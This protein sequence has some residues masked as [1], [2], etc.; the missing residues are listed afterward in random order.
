M[1]AKIT[2]RMI[3]SLIT[4]DRDRFI[5]DTEIA[6]FGIKHTRVG[7]VIYIVQSRLSGK[8]RRYTI[9]RHGA[10]WTPDKARREAISFLGRI[11][12]GEDPGEARR[13]RRRAPTVAQ[14]CDL[15]LKEGCELKKPSTIESDIGRIR[16]HIDPLLGSRRMEDIKRR[17][18]EKFLLDVAN[19]KTAVDIKTGLRGRSIVTGGKGTA[20]RTLGLLGAIFQFALNRGVIEV[21]PVRGVKRF[22]DNKCTRFLSS[23]E[24][25][26]LGKAL[27]EAEENGSQNPVGIAAIRFMALTGCG[28]GEAIKLQWNW[29]DFEQSVVYYPDSKTGAKVMLLGAPALNLLSKLPRLDGSPF[30]FPASRGD[31]YL[32]SLQDVWENIRSAAHLD[33]VR[34]HDLR[35]SYA[36]V[37]AAGGDSL[38]VIGKLLGHQNPSTTARYAHLADDPLRRASDRIG[39]V[40]VSAM[41][42]KSRSENVIELKFRPRT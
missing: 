5:W 13:K 23:K 9:G 11:A 1:H 36:S 18:I 33:D 30:V 40:I 15:Y 32:M 34:L 22:P 3:S 2:L 41:D 38:L 24:L 37:G 35:H 27:V 8:L 26:N 28:K 31:G 25:A 4:S 7:S 17:H 20:T 10:P 19:G 42:G 29:I 14:I 39:A 12:N 16:R 6:G 21:N